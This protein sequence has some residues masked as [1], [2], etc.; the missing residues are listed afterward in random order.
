MQELYDRYTQLQTSPSL[1]DIQART[2]EVI[3]NHSRVLIVVDAIDECTE[4]TLNRT[5][6]VQA[7]QS[8]LTGRPSIRGKIHLMMTSRQKETL[9]QGGDSIEIDAPEEDLE[10]LIKKRIADGISQNKRVSHKLRSDAEVAKKLTENIVK[11]AGKM[12][13]GRALVK[14][15]YK[16][17]LFVRDVS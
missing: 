3:E 1:T 16:P 14:S 17:P 5:K 12:Y 10:M 11:G 7:L 9:I 2:I 15:S 6:F 13:V 4:E 8:L